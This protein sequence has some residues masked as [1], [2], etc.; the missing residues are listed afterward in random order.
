MW[1]NL[2]I[3]L[4]LLVLVLVSVGTLLDRIRTTDWDQPL[5]VGLFP[6]SADGRDATDEYIAGLGE[7]QFRMIADFLEREASRYGL[8][9]DRPVDL[10]LHDSPTEAPPLL[11]RDAGVLRT[12]LWSLKLR[13]Y[14]WRVGGDSGEQIRIYVLYHDPEITREVPHS[15]GLQKGLVGVVYAYADEAMDGQNNIV[16]AHEL[17]HTVG[18]TDKYDTGTLQPVYPGGYAEPLR[19]PRYPQVLT[20]IMAGRRVVSTQRA[21]MPP[22]LERVVIG[23]ATAAEIRW[24]D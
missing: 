8:T 3:A 13:W 20:E 23:V 2:R 4:L 15:L 14:N 5:R 11:P 9:V 18:A 12:V 7:P 24:L 10:T 16:I 19:Q 17:L 21:E 1:R 22:D 6:I